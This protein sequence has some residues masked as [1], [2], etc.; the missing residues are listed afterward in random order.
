MT[1]AEADRFRGLRLSYSP[2]RATLLDRTCDQPTYQKWKLSP[3]HFESDYGVA[4][5]Q[6]GVQGDSIDVV[7]VDCSIKGEAVGSEIVVLSADRLVFT[8]GGVF[9]LLS[10]V[11]T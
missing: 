1:Q 7:R 11:A 8:T 9:F 3:G 2:D 6:I 4:P 5:R 10:R